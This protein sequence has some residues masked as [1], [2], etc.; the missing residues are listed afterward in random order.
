MGTDRT[1]TQTRKPRKDGALGHPHLFLIFR[2]DRPLDG[3]A[4]ISLAGVDAVAVGRGAS[5]TLSRAQEDGST[6]LRIAV[7]DPRMSTAHARLQRVLGSWV[8]ADAGSKNG[9]F[10]EGRRIERMQ[11]ADGAVLELG[12]TFFLFRETVPEPA[13]V[14]ESPQ[15]GRPR[16]F[17][18]L[19]PAFAS[20]LER[21]ERIARSS[22]P[23]LLSGETGTG[24]EV[25]ARAIHALS[26]R[27][28][29]FHAVNCAAIAPNLVESELFGHRKGAFS[30]ATEDHLGAVRTANHGTLLLDEIGDL[31]LPAQAALLR[32][33][34]ES[35]VLPVGSAKTVPVDL[36]VVAATNRDLDGLAAAQRFRPDLLARLSGYRCTLPPLRERREDFGLLSA[37]ILEQLGSPA[38]TFSVD[39]ARALLRHRWPLNVRELEKCLSAAAVLAAGGQVEVEHLPEAIRAHPDEPDEPESDLPAEGPDA[40]RRDEIL[41]LLKEHGGNVTAVARAM[42]KARTQV[43]RWL[44]RFRIDPLSFRR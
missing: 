20:E 28:G 12:H 36:R 14:V 33:L 31:P 21:I 1:L 39:A 7:P 13:D 18:T 30:G 15:A 38:L 34:Q 6:V 43:Q 5:L 19:V 8:L 11:V 24:K 27:P 10:C 42:G 40:E 3:G 2:C 26:G 9:T 35:E 4:R 23:V 17:A 25:I 22:V 32:V 41:K 37:A 16:G 44:R 29:P